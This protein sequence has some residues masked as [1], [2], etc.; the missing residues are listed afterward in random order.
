[1]NI[2][3]IVSYLSYIWTLT[4]SEVSRA[5]SLIDLSHRI[6]MSYKAKK[7]SDIPVPSQDATY[8]TLPGR[9]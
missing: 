2:E 9:E 5:M 3:Y 1:M 8:Q 7:V 6:R 4:S